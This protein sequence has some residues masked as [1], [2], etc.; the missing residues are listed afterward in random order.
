MSEPPECSIPM[1]GDDGPLYPV[2][3]NGHWVHQNCL[4][5]IAESSFPS[6]ALCP[7]CRSSCIDTL[8]QSVAVPASCLMTT[9]FSIYGATLAVVTGKLQHP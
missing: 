6:A 5:L 8:A 7:Q 2:C 1:C 9:P 3:S 4:Q